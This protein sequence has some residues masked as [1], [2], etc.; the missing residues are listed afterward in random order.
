MYLTTT[1]IFEVMFIKHCLSKFLVICKIIIQFKVLQNKITEPRYAAK[2]TCLIEHDACT[3]YQVLECKAMNFSIRHRVA[4][5]HFLFLRGSSLVFAANA[6]QCVESPTL[7]V[8]GD[9]G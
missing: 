7:G 3:A 4:I 8:L 2:C 1:N 6:F 9:L 5:V